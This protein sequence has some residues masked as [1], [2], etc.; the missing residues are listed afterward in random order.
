MVVKESGRSM[1]LDMGNVPQKRKAPG[2]SLH[3]YL[4]A[5]RQGAKVNSE[6]GPQRRSEE[7]LELARLQT[8]ESTR[9]T[10]AMH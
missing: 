8:H 10:D 9:T 3:R 2:Q 6:L 1:L 7:P 4:L 5:P